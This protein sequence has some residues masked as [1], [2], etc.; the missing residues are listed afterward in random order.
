MK[1]ESDIILDGFSGEELFAGQIG[2]TY[3][4]FLVLPGFIDF[5]PSDVELETNLTRNIKIKRPLVSSPMDTVTE[6][7]M[8]I[9]LALMG[10][11]G[12]IHYNNSMDEQVAHVRKVKRFENGFIT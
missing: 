11:I 6:A 10:G 3:R 2:L 7:S 5:N 1:K 12:I 9:A 4:D 8:A